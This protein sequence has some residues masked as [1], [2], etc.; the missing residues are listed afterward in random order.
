MRSACVSV[1]LCLSG[2]PTTSEVR[3]AVSVN[4]SARN[5]READL[6]DRVLEL[7]REYRAPPELLTL[8]VTKTAFMQSPEAA[9]RILGQLH[10]AGVCSS[11]DDF[12]SGYS[13]L[14]YLKHLPVSK[15]KIDR[16]FVMEMMSDKDDRVIVETIIDMGHNLGL[17]VVAEGVENQDSLVGLRARGCDLAQG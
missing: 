14:R 17:R 8:E 2:R 13:S 6:A 3:L 12:G 1:R 4:L 5:L 15:I 9:L 10:A 16:S 7:L 11:I